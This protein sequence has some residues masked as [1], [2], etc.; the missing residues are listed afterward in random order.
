MTVDPTWAMVIL[1]AIGLLA[2]LVAT[3]WKFAKSV[4]RM[5]QTTRTITDTLKTQWKKLDAHS[6]TLE[7]HGERLTKVETWKEIHDRLESSRNGGT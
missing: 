6:E 5:E 7:D 1:T 2:G 3:L 4:D